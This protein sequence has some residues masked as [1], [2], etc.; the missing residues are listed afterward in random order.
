LVLPQIAAALGAQYQI[1]TW[2]GW[3]YLLANVS[4]VRIVGYISDRD[5]SKT[6]FPLAPGVFI[7]GSALC[8]HDHGRRDGS[9]SQGTALTRWV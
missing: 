6:I 9:G 7:V 1:T 5:G 2:I 4:V 3:G 8:V